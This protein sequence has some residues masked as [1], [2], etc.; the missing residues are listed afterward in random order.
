V[1]RRG[2]GSLW[3]K[4]RL[5]I[6]L[7]SKNTPPF[8]LINSFMAQLK[9]N[10]KAPSSKMIKQNTSRLSKRQSTSSSFLVSNCPGITDHIQSNSKSEEFSQFTSYQDLYFNNSN[11]ENKNTAVETSHTLQLCQPINNSGINMELDNRYNNDSSNVYPDRQPNTATTKQGTTVPKLVRCDAV[12]DLQVNGTMSDLALLS[13]ETWSHK[14]NDSILKNRHRTW[15]TC[16]I[17][18]MSNLQKHISRQE[19]IL[20]SYRQKI[21]QQGIEY[22]D[23]LFWQQEAKSLEQRLDH[24]RATFGTYFHMAPTA[25]PIIDKQ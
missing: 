2:S 14:N 8:P 23:R 12:L 9:R 24:D 6:T 10:R 11:K 16:V 5:N 25:T 7:L 21:L 22:H 4:S 1:A 15:T 20:D 17:P 18:L 3:L 13:P 19:K